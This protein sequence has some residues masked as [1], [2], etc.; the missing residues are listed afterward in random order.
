MDNAQ[1]II[2]LYATDTYITQNAGDAYRVHTGTVLVFV[3][4]L[5]GDK[6]DI[7]RFLCEIEEGHLIPSFAFKDAEYINWRFLFT[8]KEE[9]QIERLP[10]KATSVLYRRFAKTAGLESFQ[11]RVSSCYEF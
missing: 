11:Y 6:P 3:A 2:R 4:P 9:A 1:E 8:T 5:K 7:R 10:G